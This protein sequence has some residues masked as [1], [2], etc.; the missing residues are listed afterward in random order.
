MP[1]ISKDD[2][3]KIWEEIALGKRFEFTSD[4]A[5]EAVLSCLRM[6]DN[7]TAKPGKLIIPNAHCDGTGE[8][9]NMLLALSKKIKEQAE[10]IATL[11]VS[12]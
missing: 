3:R 7:I 2:A 9:R 12:G 4:E 10:E 1:V 11:K 5:E 6:Y 8:I